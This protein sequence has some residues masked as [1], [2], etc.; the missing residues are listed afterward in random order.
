MHSVETTCTSSCLNFIVKGR[1][2]ALPSYVG[3]TVEMIDMTVGFKISVCDWSIF[4]VNGDDDGTAVCT[5]SM[6]LVWARGT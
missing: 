2:Y 6:D 5:L 1:R 4:V 3:A